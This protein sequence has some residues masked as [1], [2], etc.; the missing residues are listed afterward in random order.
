M[1]TMEL[2]QKVISTMSQIHGDD[3]DPYLNVTIPHCANLL[4]ETVGVLNW[5]LSS[6]NQ[7]YSQG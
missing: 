4:G 7:E 3:D 2:V 1:S 6:I 5:T